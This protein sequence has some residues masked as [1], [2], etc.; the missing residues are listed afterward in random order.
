MQ[1]QGQGQG[2]VDGMITEE[3]LKATM[4]QMLTVR[5]SPTSQIVQAQHCQCA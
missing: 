5:A 1:V 2:A 4:K 3:D